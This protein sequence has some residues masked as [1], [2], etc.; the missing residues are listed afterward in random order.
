LVEE[1]FDSRCTLCLSNSGRRVGQ[2]SLHRLA[3]YHIR[4][5]VSVARLPAEKSRLGNSTI[6]LCAA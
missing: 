5:G 3:V 4:K 1:F 2:G 6:L